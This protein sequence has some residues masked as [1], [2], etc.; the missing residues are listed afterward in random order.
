MGCCYSY[1]PDQ[2]SWDCPLANV[3]WKNQSVSFRL[4]FTSASYLQI[5][6]KRMNGFCTH[7]CTWIHTH[8]HMHKHHN[9]T[10]FR[11]GFACGFP[12]D[13]AGKE[14]ACSV[15]DLDLILGL[16][17]FPGEGKGYPL[18]YSG[19]ENSMDYTVAKSSKES[20]RREQLS[21]SLFRT[22]QSAAIS[23]QSPL[24]SFCQHCCISPLNSL[25]SAWCFAWPPSSCIYVSLPQILE[26]RLEPWL[27]LVS[28][29]S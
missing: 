1:L 22:S 7:M 17:R 26:E 25:I 8:T 21:L 18:Q 3:C 24:D 20:D 23:G 19:L 12:C 9:E 5:Q 14:S 11:T 28:C 4:V 16:G 2:Q 10:F 15:G 27:P 29:L 13:S 6:G